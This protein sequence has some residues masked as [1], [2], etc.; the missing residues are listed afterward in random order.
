MSSLDQIPIEAE[1]RKKAPRDYLALTISLVAL[2]VSITGLGLSFKNSVQQTELVRPDLQAHSATALPYLMGDTQTLSLITLIHNSGQLAADITDV[3]ATPSTFE[4]RDP[5]AKATCDDESKRMIYKDFSTRENAHMSRG[6]QTAIATFMELPESCW[7]KAT[8]PMFA[9]LHVTY[10]DGTK[11][12]YEN[13]L[14][15]LVDLQTKR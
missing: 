9:D 13:N 4:I 15:I 14:H 7:A 1:K 10:E 12:R 6:D 11:K 3:K 5:A 8:P 2:A